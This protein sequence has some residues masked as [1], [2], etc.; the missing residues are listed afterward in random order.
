LYTP[1]ITPATFAEDEFHAFWSN[2]LRW[3]RCLDIWYRYA[4]SYTDWITVALDIKTTRL[5]S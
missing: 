2:A 4:A 3:V 5:W 1:K